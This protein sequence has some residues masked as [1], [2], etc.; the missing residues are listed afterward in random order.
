M[1]YYKPTTKLGVKKSI[2]FSAALLSG[3]VSLI[4]VPRKVIKRKAH[5]VPLESTEQVQLVLWLL[6]KGLKFTSIPN[7]TYTTSWSQKIK[8]K[9]QGLNAGFPDLVVIVKNKMLFVELKRVKKSLSNVS[10]EQKSWIEEINKCEGVEARV[11]YGCD[12]AK[13]FISEYL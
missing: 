1:L 10:D 8:N 13:E 12:K 4:T 9:E 11:C 7:S 6:K 5:Q 3:D 2:E